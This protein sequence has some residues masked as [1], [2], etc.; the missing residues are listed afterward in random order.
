MAH[1]RKQGFFIVDKEPDQTIRAA[2]PLIAKVD[3]I[4]G[5]PAGR[6]SLVLLATSFLALVIT[7]SLQRRAWNPWRF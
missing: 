4:G 3:R 5:Y 1:I 7:Y 2:H 6:T